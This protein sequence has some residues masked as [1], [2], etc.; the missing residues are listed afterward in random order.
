MLTGGVAIGDLSGDGIPEI[1]FASY[2]TD[3]DKS[4]LYIVD[5]GGNLQHRIALPRR[6]A[7]PVPTLADVNGDGTV[8]I[9]VSLK[10]AVDKQES[11]LVYTIAGSATNCLPWPTGRADLLRSGVAKR[12]T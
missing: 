11:V 5:A 2:S 7:M 6:G 9:L 4:A 3:A 10:D 12:A 8:E 1:V